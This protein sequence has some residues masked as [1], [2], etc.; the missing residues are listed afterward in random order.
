MFSFNRAAKTRLFSTSTSP[1][2]LFDESK[3]L[4]TVRLKH[5]LQIEEAGYDYQ[6]HQEEASK[7]MD[8]IFFLQKESW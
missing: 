8:M 2:S 1:M 6:K 7:H 4:K 5:D 3:L